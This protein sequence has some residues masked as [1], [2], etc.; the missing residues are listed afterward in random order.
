MTITM[1]I[2]VCDC[3]ANP[4]AARLY[5]SYR[6][7]RLESYLL[8]QL[9]Q[10]QIRSCFRKSFKDVCSLRPTGHCRAYVP[11]AKSSVRRLKVGQGQSGSELG[12]DTDPR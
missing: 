10:N 1:T 2:T 6:T 7:I 3:F 4:L 9:N 12:L 8:R 5:M 11:Y